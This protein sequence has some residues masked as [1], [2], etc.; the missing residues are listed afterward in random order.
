MLK[1]LTPVLYVDRVED[2]L[3]F[4]MDLLGFEKTVEVPHDG[5][6]GFA[7]LI[8]DSVEIMI[9]SHASVA[10]DV[11]ALA[12]EKARVPMFFE[13]S[14][15]DDIEERLANVEKV[16]PRRTTFYGATEIAVRDPAG[17]VVTFAQFGA[18]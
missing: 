5:A 17:N 2:Q 6:L 15:L 18:A 13:T 7:I 8:R 3:P 9:Q 10:A 11:P 16:F 1:K 12:G 14:N 4:W